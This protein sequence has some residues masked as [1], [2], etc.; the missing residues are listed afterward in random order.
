LVRGETDWRPGR[1]QR[2]DADPP[3]RELHGSIPRLKPGDTAA[4]TVLKP[5]FPDPLGG[6][7]SG[8]IVA[9]DDIDPGIAEVVS[10]DAVARHRV[11]AQPPPE[12]RSAAHLSGHGGGIALQHYFPA[13]V[14]SCI[15]VRAPICLSRFP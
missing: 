13:K 4:A 11:R 14:V 15:V 10:E 8:D 12:Q 1:P 7:Q 5:Q 6:R 2:A 9:V 3:S